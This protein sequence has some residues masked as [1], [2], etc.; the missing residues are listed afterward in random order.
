MI[1]SRTVATELDSQEREVFGEEY[2][3]LHHTTYNK[4]FKKLLTKKSTFVK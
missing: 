1:E 2:I 3:T 4:N